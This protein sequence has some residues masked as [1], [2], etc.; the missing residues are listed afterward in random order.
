MK[1]WDAIHEC[2]DARDADRLKKHAT[3]TRESQTLTQSL[4]GDFPN[5]D[6]DDDPISISINTTKI[7]KKEFDAMQFVLKLKHSEW[8]LKP[9]NKN[10]SQSV[11]NSLP[12]PS[13]NLLKEWKIH[14]T[15][16]EKL[17]I[18][19][20][21]NALNTSTQSDITIHTTDNISDSH[22]NNKFDNI[23][24]ET[25]QLNMS[26][27]PV[28]NT[29]RMIENQ[30]NL[31]QKQLIAFHIAA[32]KFLHDQLLKKTDNHLDNHEQLQYSHST[33][34]PL[35][36]L[37]TGPGG[38]GKTHVVKALQT[39]M[40]TYGCEH[41]IRFLAPTGSAAAIIGGMTIHKG[42]GINIVKHNKHKHN[43]NASDSTEDYSVVINIKCKSQL[44]EEWK[45]V[46]FLLIDE[47]SLLSQQL[48]CEIDHALRYAKEECNDWFGGINVIFAGDFYQYPPVIGSP[49]YTPISTSNKI[50]ND[51]LKKRL[52]R[53]A[54]KTINTVVNFDEQKR[55][56][57][58]PSYAQ[59]ISR[60]RLR[61]CNFDDVSLFNSRVI[62][63]LDNPNGINMS[64][65]ENIDATCIVHT[66][67][68]RHILNEYKVRANI[69]NMNDLVI[70]AALDTIDH[71]I[72]STPIHEELLKLN[73][74][75]IKDSHALPGYISLYV[76][77]PIILR[78]KNLSTD[79]KITNGSQGFVRNIST[80]IC[81]SN[82]T[83]A[84]SIL[85]EFPDSPIHIPGLPQSYFPVEPTKWSFTTELHTTT[86]KNYKVHVTRQQLPIQA[87]FAVTGHSA[88]G[89]KTLQKVLIN[90][91]EGGFSAYVGGSR[92]T[93]REG[94]CITEPISLQDLN[95]PLP[96]ALLFEAR[97]FNVIEWNTEI[98]HKIRTGPLKPIPDAE[99]DLPS[100]PMPGKPNFLNNSN[101][102]KRKV[103][104]KSLLHLT[105][106]QK[107]RKTDSPA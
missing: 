76:G 103:D 74:T 96:Y 20:R 90:L 51:N 56:A 35:C 50:D 82:L 62:K 30:Y 26:S 99:A 49:L 7:A 58:D 15:N 101:E 61:E 8:F 60:L 45:N 95:K 41:Q 25:G 13:P 59:A 107:K 43:Q 31:N 88:Q 36:M 86:N 52:G 97:K 78:D 105:H 4:K 53:L 9:S 34:L 38:T 29:L 98:I 83:Y 32:S 40:A 65:I 16:Q 12:N 23:I 77:M 44:R 55:M 69:N 87:A 22:V 93:S 85:A 63:S 42:L 28:K 67:H 1:N 5:D 79:L 89:K 94:L 6:D 10:L 70:C 64:N 81:T 27:Q 84:T 75:S 33:D 57:A 68:V 100:I 104:K 14:I 19:K 17:I 66:N 3:A 11:Q 18:T 2:E 46:T 21:Q 106:T 48:L 47:V 71:N 72:P 24:H 102:L 39:L 73:I 92:A 80:R 91:K 54:W 37:I